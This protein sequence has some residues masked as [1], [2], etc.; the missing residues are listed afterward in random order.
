MAYSIRSNVL[1]MQPYTPGKPIDEVK[2]ELGLTHVVKLASNENPLGPSP[3]AVE[4]IRASAESVHLYPDASGY[5]LKQAIAN[6]VGVDPSGIALGNGSDELIRL[7]AHT[8]VAPGD[9]I[10]IGNPSFVRYDAAAH[11][12]DAALI[13]VPLTSEWR[14]DLPAMAAAVTPKT[15]LVYLANPHNPCGTTV[16][17]DEVDA[18]LATLPPHVVVVLDEAYYEYAKDQPN[19][20][21]A[22]SLISAGKP[23]VSL[24]TFSK[25]YGLAGIRIGYA[26][27]SPTL[28]E[29]MGRTREPFHV[30]SLA[31]AAAIAAL[32]DRDFIHR[33]VALNNS[34]RDRLRDWMASRGF[35]T[36]ESSANFVCVEI[37]PMA[38]QV[39]EN[40]LKEGVIVRNGGPLGMPKHI[41]VSIGNRE[42]MDY[43]YT[44]F[45]KVVSALG[46]TA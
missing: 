40:L 33:S 21:V 1:R 20:P 29:A 5:E 35:T 18:F 23:V 4:A 12:S 31:Q 43:F 28:I 2:R 6:F 32:E 19:Q 36:V 25:A 41:R 42:E 9:E 17:R 13:A 37:G 30:N 16:N 24:R 15:K 22:T 8:L 3:K 26:I 44:A 46:V 14:H 11:I 39:F 34:E 10:L 27:G 45:E 7:L 38:T